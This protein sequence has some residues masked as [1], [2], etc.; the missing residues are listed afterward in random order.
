MLAA[1]R[2]AAPARIALLAIEIRLDG[3]LVARFY[4][5]N[6]LT[7]GQHLCPQFMPGDSRIGKEGHL[8]KISAEIGAT[9]PDTLYAQ[10]RFAWTGFVGPRD[11][12]LT[13]ALRFFEQE[14]F[15][16]SKRGS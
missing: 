2:E 16:K 15:H 8:A 12:R 1:I 7:D 6:A 10:Q 9:D 13:P 3:A 5:R 14:C 4:V 11:I